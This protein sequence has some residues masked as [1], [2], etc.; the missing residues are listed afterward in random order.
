MIYITAAATTT[1]ADATN[2]ILITVNAA[3]TGTITVRDAG[4]A[5]AVITNPTVGTAY[6][7]YG[8]NGAVSLVTNANTDITVSI[9]N[10]TR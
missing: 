9:L 4:V 1:V 5:V 3:L 2:G 6:R 8:F 7:Y 10:T